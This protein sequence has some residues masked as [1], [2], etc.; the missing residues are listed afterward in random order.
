MNFIE[1]I[2]SGTK[3]VL[4]DLGVTLNLFR[5]VLTI[6]AFPINSREEKEV[7]RISEKTFKIIRGV[8][9]FVLIPFDV[10][11][12]YGID[13]L[14]NIRDWLWV[15]LVCSIIYIIIL[16]PLVLCGYI[17][18]YIAIKSYYIGLLNKY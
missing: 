5:W 11:C 4:E 14:L 12:N 18:V 16:I 8:T 3:N 1:K 9:F 2:A 13:I 17:L 7:P 10:I 6:K 15:F